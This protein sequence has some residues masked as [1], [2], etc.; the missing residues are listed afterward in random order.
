ML[1]QAGQIASKLFWIGYADLT[2]GRIAAMGERYA[3]K[4]ITKMRDLLPPCQVV[5]ANAVDEDYQRS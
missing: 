2:R 1:D 5:A 3:G 4:A